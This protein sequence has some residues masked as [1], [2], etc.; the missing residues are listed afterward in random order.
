[1]TGHPWGGSEELWS[2]AALRLQQAGHTISAS[3]DKTL[4]V[5]PK[6][7]TLIEQGIALRLREPA[8]GALLRAIILRLTAIPQKDAEQ[9]WVRVQKP[10]LVVVSMGAISDGGHWLKYCRVAGLP[11]AVI[12]QSNSN[13]LWLNDGYAEELAELYR[14]AKAVY[15]VARHNLEQLE[16][17]LGTELPNAQVVWNPNNAAGLEMLPWPPPKE[18]LQLACVARLE[19][20]AKGQDILLQSLA[21][22]EWRARPVDLNLY[23]SGPNEKILRAMGQRLKLTNIHFH[24]HVANLTK[25]WTANHM[26]VLPSRSE[27]LPLT[28]I[29]AMSCGR[30]AV[31]T[32]VGGNAELCVD[33][34]TGFVASAAA[35]APLAE[36]LERAWTRR[37]EW[38]TMGRAARARV[39]QIVPRDP[40]V[41][42]GELVLKCVKPD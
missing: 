1:M 35:E 4:P 29:E 34:Q 27:G 28:L 18:R 26:L 14:G 12:S 39:L 24:G 9:E 22:P 15:C 2:Q 36:A 38:E 42:F 25:I 17:Q 6:L 32:D 20:E 8:R 7:T 5:S 19:L 37:N 21:R 13:A 33:G 23:G 40:V 3:T 31:V 30:P 10:D 11:Y 41:D 16:R